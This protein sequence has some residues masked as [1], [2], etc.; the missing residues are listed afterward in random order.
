MYVAGLSNEE[1]A[2]NFRRLA[3]PFNDHMDATSLEIFHVAHGRYETHAPVRTFMP[4]EID[5]EPQILAAYTCTS[6]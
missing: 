6:A 5:G 2:S 4:F 3:F 1:F